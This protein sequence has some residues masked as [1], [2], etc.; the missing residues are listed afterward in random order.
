[1]Y[2]IRGQQVAT[3][4]DGQRMAGIHNV[5]WSAADMPSGIYLYKLDVGNTTLTKKVTLLK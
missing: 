5:Q 1:V 3:L 2:N 4:V